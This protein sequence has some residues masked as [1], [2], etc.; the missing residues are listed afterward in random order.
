MHTR[1]YRLTLAALVGLAVPAAATEYEASD[2]LPLAVGNSWT[3]HHEAFDEDEKWLPGGADPSTWPAYA[4]HLPKTPSFTIT[5]ERTEVID[6]KT[7]YVLSDMPSGGWP[8]APPHFLAGKKLRWQGAHLMER[9]DSGEQESL[10]RFDGPGAYT[11]PTTEGDNEVQSSVRPISDTYPV[12]EFYFHFHGYD[13]Y[14]EWP[15]GEGEPWWA[16]RYCRFLAG[17]GLGGCGEFIEV[18]DMG[19]EFF[20][21]INALGATLVKKSRF[22]GGSGED[23]DDSTVT[24]S[25][26]DA[27]RGRGGDTSLSS[28]SWGEI[29]ESR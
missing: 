11:I 15:G 17:Y 12:P 4:A 2:Y 8:P 18:S 6:G 7:Y 28:S 26:G 27:R 21:E 20:N 14:G 13:G 5:V 1:I 10:F 22:V 9:T 23:S 19:K 29:K 16:A 3:F 24:V 25:Y